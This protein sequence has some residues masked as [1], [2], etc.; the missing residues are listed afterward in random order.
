MAEKTQ[1]LFIFV[2]DFFISFF[3]FLQHYRAAVS[4]SFEYFMVDKSD[5]TLLRPDP[6]AAR[7]VFGAPQYSMSEREREKVAFC[8]TSAVAASHIPSLQ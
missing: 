5:V 3:S 7:E 4:V 6:P 2:D 8:L 1:M